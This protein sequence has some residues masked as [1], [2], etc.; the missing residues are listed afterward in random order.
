MSAA[1][2]QVLMR[3]WRNGET[4]HIR[5]PLGTVGPASVSESWA[6]MHA[7]FPGVQA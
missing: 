1:R 3:L 6:K 4:S 7:M 5:H 2:L